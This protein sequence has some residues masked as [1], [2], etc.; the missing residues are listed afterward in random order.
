[1]LIAGIAGFAQFVFAGETNTNS[2]TISTYMTNCLGEV[3][4]EPYRYH[5]PIKPKKPY[6]DVLICSKKG[7]K[8]VRVYDP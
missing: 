5:K 1:M 6:R 3:V 4:K 8:V 7:C 2:N